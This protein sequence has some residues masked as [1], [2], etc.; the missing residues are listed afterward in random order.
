[1][2]SDLYLI[3]VSDDA[4]KTVVKALPQFKES[5]ILAHTSG[6]VPSTI[7]S[8]RSENYG[9][10]YP[11][12]TFLKTQEV[13]MSIVPFLVY[14]STPAA[15]RFLRMTATKLSSNVTE[16]NDVER[17]HY[18]LSAVFINN[19]TNHIA[20]IADQYLNSNE[21]DARFLNP[22]MKTTFQKILQGQPCDSQ[23]GPAKREDKNLMNKHLNLLESYPEWKEV[24][25]SVSKSITNQYANTK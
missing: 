6:S 1:M 21:L 7:L 8:L 18:H 5:Q 23:T 19:F 22:L 4:I 15:L 17:L 11:L 2:D 24:Y 12:Q 9:S 16:I 10:F 14:G 3:M 20:C 25:K 13:D